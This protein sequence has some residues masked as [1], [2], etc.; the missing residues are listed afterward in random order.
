MSF[1]DHI[2]TYIYG[3]SMDCKLEESANNKFRIKLSKTVMIHPTNEL[4]VTFQMIHS[5][6]G[7]KLCEVLW[8]AFTLWAAEHHWKMKRGQSNLHKHHL[9]NVAKIWVIGES[10]RYCWHFQCTILNRTGNSHIQIEHEC[11]VCIQNFDA[12]ADEPCS[13]PSQSLSQLIDHE[14]PNL[15]IK[16]HHWREDLV[17]IDVEWPTT[18]IFAVEKSSISRY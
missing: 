2:H 14:W 6:C 15:Y 8:V 16:S 3:N 11:K 13:S 9:E 18:R 5:A 4:L 17:Y 1:C 10:S 7:N 12:L